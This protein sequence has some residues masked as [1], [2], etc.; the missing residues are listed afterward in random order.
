MVVVPCQ[1]MGPEYNGVPPG[2][3]GPLQVGIHLAADF[4]CQQILM[5]P[6][7]GLQI[8]KCFD[9]ERSVLLKIIDLGGEHIQGFFFFACD[10]LT[11]ILTIPFQYLISEGGK[12]Q[13][14]NS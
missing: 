4:G 14:R 7:F 1:E 13:Q 2:L 3:E 6:T 8:E 5:V 9:L 11:R 12:I 10:I